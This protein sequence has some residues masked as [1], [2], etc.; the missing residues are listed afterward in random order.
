MEISEEIKFKLYKA[1]K[2]E[3]YPN[4]VP[5]NEDWVLNFLNEIWALRL[6]P[7]E[8]GRFSNAYDDIVQHI[9]NNDDWDVDYLFI[10]RLKL[11][12]DDDKYISFLERIVYPSLIEENIVEK[13][14]LLI[15]SFLEL[16]DLII[17]PV[18]YDK[19]Q[20]LIYKVKKKDDT[21]VF[22]DF[23]ENKIPF[24]V[25][26]LTGREQHINFLKLPNI[27]PCFILVGDNW[28]DYNHVTSFTLYFYNK[29]KEATKIG[30][31]KITD[32]INK[33]IRGVIPHQFKILD[34]SF[35]SLG[36]TYEY[37]E[38][39]KKVTG[40]LFE[41]VLHA[42][43]DAAFFSLIHEKFETN[44][45]FIKSLI[46]EDEAE[47]LLRE[48]KYKINGYDMNDLYS[49]K[50]LFSPKYT[51]NEANNLI[52][53]DFEFDNSEDSLNRIYA[54]IGKNG[55]GKT[56]FITNLPQDISK[57]NNELFK[58]KTPLFSKVI[59]VSYSTFDNFK[60]PKKTSSFNYVY[61]G[62]FK[63]NGKILTTEEQEMRFHKTWKN[64][65]YLERI[66]QWRS[67]L[68]NFISL[69]IIK[70]LI[71]K[72]TEK[73]LFENNR[74]TVSVKGFNKIKNQLSS[75]QA[76]ML[77]V[78]TEIV[79]NIRYDSLLLFDEPETHLH[80]N[81]ISQLINTI[82]EL[83]TEF[84]SFCILTTHSPIVIQQLFSK[85]VYVIEKHEN[86]PSIRKIGIE[87]FGE[88]LTTLTEEVFGNKE[89]EHQYKKILDR[90]VTQGMSYSEIIETLTSDEIPLSLNARL[91]LKS[92]VKG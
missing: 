18:S 38:E 30:Y 87:S 90:L 8:D 79:S 70:L 35:C 69:D 47:R 42:L 88:N 27:V 48:A 19:N 52:N 39:L 76:I 37:Y 72:D 28:N 15:N 1:L 44:Y 33:D 4:G 56:Q 51:N 73:G 17:L 59:A 26:N 67:V 50:Y 64:I 36:Q 60:I 77:Y 20:R 2:L 22:S 32:G 25:K 86:I 92:I 85:N 66:I 45:A 43:K 5:E 16:E 65:E 74:M 58:P 68:L 13:L 3:L 57:N 63:K 31:L 23:P 55:T 6:M 53:L 61:C 82:Y 21:S 54:V 46:R 10:T 75:G 49:F 89:T 34:D 14:E 80:P 24:Y 41:S 7:S 84:Q 83:V 78:L 29:N 9:V 91:Y 40:V 11:L 62:L 12:E 81:A 71:I